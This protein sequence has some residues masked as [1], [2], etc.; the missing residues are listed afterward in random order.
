MLPRLLLAAALIA[1]VVWF[2]Q[3]GKS[4]PPPK[5]RKYYVSF[6]LSLLAG[7]LIVLAITG[8]VHW[9]GAMIGALI[10]VV[11]T[12]FPYALQF[13]P[14]F[15]RRRATG[16]DGA[17]PPPRGNTNMTRDEALSVLGLH[18]PVTRED[19]IA[20]HRSLMQKLHP[21]RGGND[22]LASQLNRAKDVLLG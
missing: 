5:R 3:R 22:Y 16:G 2:V 12:L 15:L 10:P 6:G 11:R 1:I 13:L 19:I 18:D 20:A 21:D 8:R 7:L 9:I 17:S 4:L 14:S